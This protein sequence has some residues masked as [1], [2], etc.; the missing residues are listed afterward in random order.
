MPVFVFSLGDGVAAL[1]ERLVHEAAIPTFRKLYPETSGWKLSLI[2]I[3]AT[4]MIESAGVEKTSAGRHI[5]KMFRHQ[6]RMLQDW[7][8]EDRHIPSPPSLPSSLRSPATPPRKEDMD[9]D[10][11]PESKRELLKN[12]IA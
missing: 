8:V 12:M 7:R 1:A 3:A 4:N 5:G 6:E 9:I 2:N 10:S 11:G